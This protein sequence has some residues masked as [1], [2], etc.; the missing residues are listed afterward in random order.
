[1]L[2]H[3]SLISAFSLAPEYAD[4]PHNQPGDDDCGN[5]GDADVVAPF[6]VLERR[7]VVCSDGRYSVCMIIRHDG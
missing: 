4:T 2:S 1:V 7:L 3:S 5:D 6:E